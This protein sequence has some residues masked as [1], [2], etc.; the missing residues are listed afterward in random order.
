MRFAARPVGAQSNNRTPLAARILRIELTIV[1][2]PTPGP[3]VITS[4]FAVSARRI[5]ALWL[6]A[7]CRPL[8]FSTQGR[9]F[10]SSI[11]GQGNLPLTMRISRAADR[12]LGPVESRQEGARGVADLVGDH[13]A[14]GSF[15]LEGRQDQVLWRF[16]LV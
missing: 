13:G 3:P 12:L 8:R 1:V 6:S 15:E 2:L 11:H 7:S 4:A 16:V 5:A 14:L 9:A 10:S